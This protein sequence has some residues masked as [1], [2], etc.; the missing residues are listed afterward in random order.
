MCFEISQTL[1][2]ACFPHRKWRSNS[3]ATLR[4]IHS[5]DDNNVSFLFELGNKT[6]KILGI[7]KIGTF[8]WTTNGY[9]LTRSLEN[10]D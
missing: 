9:R 3:T 6:I 10:V 8:V 1:K 5:F 7:L 4:K 2:S